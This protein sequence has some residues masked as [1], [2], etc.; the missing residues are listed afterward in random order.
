[1][2]WHDQEFVSEEGF[3]VVELLPMDVQFE[4]ATLAH[5]RK[6]DTS[7]SNAATNGTGEFLPMHTQVKHI[8]FA[9]PRECKQS[10]SA[11]EKNVQVTD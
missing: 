1:M 8:A 10:I 5:P 4:S 7:I 9:H 3:Q 2:I 6:C 11:I